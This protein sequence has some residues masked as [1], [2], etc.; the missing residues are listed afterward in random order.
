MR[1]TG[2]S[3]LRRIPDLPFVVALLFIAACYRSAEEHSGR[4][5][6]DTV[7]VAAPG[8]VRVDIVVLVDNS[9][10]MSQEQAALTTA[11]PA[12]IRDLVEPADDDGD[13]RPDHA[14]V[15]DLHVGVITSDMGTMGFPVST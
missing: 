13:G 12:L 11:F 6:T 5:P 1:R 8:P 3:V 7:P 9:G 15:D 4:P 2:R 10:S 14:P